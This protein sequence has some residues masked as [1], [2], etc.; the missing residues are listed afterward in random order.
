MDGGAW[1]STVRVV[2]MS[3]I[4]L[5]DYTQIYRWWECKMEK[6]FWKTIWHFFKG[7]NMELPFEPAVSLLD[8][9]PREMKTCPNR[10]FEGSQEH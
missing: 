7:L 10:K 5:S 9:Y 3:H 8:I 6:S 1:W 4:Q 2:T